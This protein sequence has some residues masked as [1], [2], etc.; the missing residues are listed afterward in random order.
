MTRFVMKSGAGYLPLVADDLDA[1]VN[2]EQEGK[3][4][5]RAYR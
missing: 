1:V 4:V 5:R 3:L 2:A